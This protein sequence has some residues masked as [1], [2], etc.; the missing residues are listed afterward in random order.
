[1][2]L[3]TLRDV[4][5]AFGGP[6]LLESVNL[7]IERGE[8]LCLLGRNG[9]GKSTLLRV[10]NGEL[11]PD[12]GVVWRAQDVRSAYLSQAVPLDLSGSVHDVIARGLAGDYSGDAWQREHQIAKVLSQL[13][14]DGSV[15]CAALSAGLKRRV[16]LAQGLVRE[17][18]LLLL[19]EPTNHLDVESIA[20]LEEFLMRY[21]GTLLF[22]THD[23]MFLRRLA[24]RIIELDR[25]QLSDWDCDYDAFLV[26]KQAA[27]ENEAVERALFDK[28]LAK[29]EVWVRQGIRARRT[30]N[31]GRVRALEQ[32]RRLR[33]ERRERT[34]AVRMAAQESERS[35]QLVIET[36]NVSYGYGD[37][38]IIRDLSTTIMRGDRVGIIGPN[39]SGKTTLLRILL[40]ELAPQRGTVRH[41]TRLNIAYYDQ[42]RAQL[43]EDQ[44]AYENIGQGRDHVIINGEPR[45]VIGYLQDFLF[46][47]ERARLAVRVLSGGERNRLLL[48]RLFARPTNILVLDEPTN[49][50]DVETLD[51][52]EELLLDFDGTFLLVSH[53][54]AFLNNV[55]TSVL[56]LEGDGRVGEYAGG[57]DDW[58]RQRRVQSVPKDA[59]PSRSDM[60]KAEAAR[61]AIRQAQDSTPR[62]SYKE[63]RA[64]E[65][66]RQ[67]LEALPRRIE[68]LE[69]AQREL[70]QAM[71]T[72]DFYKQPAA[73]IVKSN[74]RLH[75]LAA[76]V[77]AAYAR[78]EEIEQ[79]LLAGTAGV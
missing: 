62:L 1:M 22:V 79:K 47:P 76:E 46:E 57:Y 30:R 41:G 69:C 26:R 17:P 70:A 71:A 64:R 29:E 21:E 15:E 68:A 78:W 36:E 52:L 9:T 77:A 28:K 31:E 25:G 32:M 23:R 54:R 75:S 60:P 14:L 4:S 37:R 10:V 33:S 59:L 49:D 58:L 63:Q 56:A 38:P 5:L 27:L 74:E 50:L 16:L 72:A 24:T 13:N 39:G 55:V 34:G 35:G 2:S 61:R 11:P 6:W 18:D 19:D 45:H 48:A 12:R 53:D 65:A 44:S 66:L 8:R 73:D 51:L 20:S 40:G 43:D 67:E 3:I 7:Q 42:L